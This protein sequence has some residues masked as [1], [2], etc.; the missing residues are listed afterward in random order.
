MACVTFTRGDFWPTGSTV[1]GRATFCVTTP[2]TYDDGSFS[3]TIMDGFVFDGPSI[4][5]WALPF[6]PVGQLFLPSALHDY[7]QSIDMPASLA[8]RIF[9]NA[10]KLNGVNEPVAWLIY[11]A[12]RFGSWKNGLLQKTAAAR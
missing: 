7:L 10:I 12:V 9:Y 11:A 2:F 3:I 4:P 5:F 1:N 6:C 8:D